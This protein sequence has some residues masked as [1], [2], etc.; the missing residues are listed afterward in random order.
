MMVTYGHQ[1][2]SAEDKF[3]ALAE[4]VRKNDKGAAGSTIVDLIP[5][6]KPLPCIYLYTLLST[7]RRTSEVHP[8]MVSR[9]GIP[10]RSLT[11]A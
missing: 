4:A 3:V 6:C 7:D 5:I 11:R 9:C 10:T 1:V 8:G 2:T